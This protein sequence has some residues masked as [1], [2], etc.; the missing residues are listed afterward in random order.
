MANV[1]KEVIVNAPVQKVYDFWRNFENFP[2]FMENIESI[3]VTG[4]DESH[5]KMKGP[6]GQTI[7]WDAKTT[8]VQENKKISWQSTEG[9]IETH[10]SVT[11]EEVSQAQTKVTVGLEFTPPLGALGEIVAK[12]TSNPEAQLEADL[13]RFRN[14]A[15]SEDFGQ[16]TSGTPAVGEGS[17]TN[18]ASSAQRP[19]IE[20]NVVGSGSGVDGTGTTRSTDEVA[21]GPSH[22]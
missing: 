5:W 7:E 15:E 8:S 1:I 21:Q 6:L 12:L 14:V 19:D 11:F 20:G 2:R 17:Y 4:P 16:A 22:P 18:S 10:G 9:T 3:E 13:K